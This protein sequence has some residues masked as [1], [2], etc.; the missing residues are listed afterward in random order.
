MLALPVGSV[1]EYL[2]RIYRKVGV[3]NRTEL[4][5]RHMRV[6]AETPVELIL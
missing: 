3:R 2:Y 6:N 1:K 4:A 5:L